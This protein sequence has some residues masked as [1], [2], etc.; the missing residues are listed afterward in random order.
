[1]RCLVSSTTA[2]RNLRRVGGFT[3]VELIAVLLIVA[4]M[5]G[6][7][8]PS[9]GSISGTRASMAARQ[10]LR[11]M[12]FARQRA[13]ATGTTCWVKF[14]T[15][16]KTW[17]LLRD[18]P[19]NPGLANAIIL[20]DLAT[21]STYILTLGSGNF[22]SVDFSSCNFDSGTSVG[23]NWLGEPMQANGT[24]LAAQG[25]V[26]LTNNHQITVNASTG[27]VTHITP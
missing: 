23:F 22:A 6:V 20:T 27:M 17:T 16:A 25:S 5:A 21:G 11:D 3:L 13:L 4:I 12:T 24:A 1:M 18:D 10:L 7:A 26:V 19:S 9:L 8:V 14:D 15:T 2:R